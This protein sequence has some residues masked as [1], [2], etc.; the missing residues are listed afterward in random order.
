MTFCSNK[1]KKAFRSTDTPLVQLD[2]TFDLE[3]DRYKV[4]AVVYLNPDTNKTEVAFMALLCDETKSN[5]EFALQAFKKICIRYDL[6][7]MVDKD[8]GHWRF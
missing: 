8:F 6:I 1:M 7:F 2:N 4:M 3:K 5:V